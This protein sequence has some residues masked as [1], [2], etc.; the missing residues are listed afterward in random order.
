MATVCFG[1]LRPEISRSIL[2][3]S[4][5]C[6]ISRL[7]QSSSARASRGDSV[8]TLAVLGIWCD[9]KS[10][11]CSYSCSK[12][13]DAWAISIASCFLLFVREHALRSRGAVISLS[14]AWVFFPRAVCA[15][16]QCWHQHGG[17]PLSSICSVYCLQTFVLDTDS[18]QMAQ[19]VVSTVLSVTV[20]YLVQHLMCLVCFL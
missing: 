20:R 14:E 19:G 3:A 12:H 13:F 15:R 18:R 8:S 11:G 7:R 1:S 4:R 5:Y 10:R 6:L 9:S 16:V 2:V 17:F